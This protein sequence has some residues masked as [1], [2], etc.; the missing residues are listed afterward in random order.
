MTRGIYC[1]A[2]GIAARECA[3][4]M[5]TSAKKHMPDVPIALC[6]S[7]KIGLEDV[8]IVEEDSD[9]GGR[10]AKLRAYDLAPK[11]WDTVLYLDADTEIIAPVYQLFRWCEDGW[12]FVICRD[13][14]ETG[15]SFHRKNNEAEYRQLE[16]AVGT[17]YA[18]QFNGG[19]WVFRRCDATKRLLERWRAEWEIHA[20]RDQGALMR[21]IHADPVR[22]LVLGNEWNCFPKY[23]PNVKCAGIMH[24]PGDA[25]RWVGKLPGRIDSAAAWARVDS[26]S[27][28]I[29]A[30]TIQPRIPPPQPGRSIL[31][32]QSIRRAR[33]KRAA[34]AVQS[35]EIGGD[36]SIPCKQQGLLLEGRQE[37]LTA[38]MANLCKGAPK[39]PAVKR[40]VLDYQML[41]LYYLAR[42]YDHGRILEIGTG[43]GGSAY[44]LAHA[45]PNATVVSIT[46]NPHEKID[47]ERYWRSVGIK[48]ALVV[49]EPSWDFLARTEDMFDFVFIDGDHNRI[50]RDLPW[51]N[52]LNVGGLMVC[53]DY[54]PQDSRTPSGIVFDELNAL[55]DRLGRPFD[56]SLIDEGKVGMVGFYRREGEC[57]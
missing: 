26:R 27:R 3:L 13:V 41:A 4:R 47:A 34:A 22:M 1:V 36:V 35:V 49:V 15:H 40:K 32:R 37:T 31:D 54:S 44:M 39:F 6:S 45:A 42:A 24:Y 29:T 33:L 46:T 10:R 56:V 52:R 28:P 43:H 19:V 14:G 9:V 48:H 50:A 38:A 5:M 16:R 11:E 2:F 30:P 20:Q 23:T 25:R 51:F 7:S 55:R 8:L 57:A 18:L 17:L 21:A 53:H 12:E